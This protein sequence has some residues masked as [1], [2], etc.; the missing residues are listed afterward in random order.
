MLEALLQETASQGVS[1]MALYALL[2]G[3][4][5]VFLFP[6]SIFMTAA[7]AAF[8]LARG[9]LVAQSAGWLGAML[10]FLVSRYLAR[11]RVERWVA[12]K[13]SFASVDEAIGKEGWKIVLLS[14]C[15]P[16]F[17]YIFQN[18]AFGLSR[19]SFAGYALAT[20][21]GLIPTTLVFAYLGSLGRSGAETVSGDES[22]LGLA[23]KILGL[24]ATVVVC[25]FIAR[26]SR[27]ALAKA[28]V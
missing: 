22:M 14:R 25:V 20:F 11:P 2:S 8:G 3:V 7:G 26:V 23:L 12:T 28:G 21:V 27:R 9:F 10:A 4:S 1:G 17:P 5:V 19:V 13:P 18:Y 15:C 24:V 6:G 16:V